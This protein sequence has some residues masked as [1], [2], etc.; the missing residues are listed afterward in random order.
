VNTSQD[1]RSGATAAAGGDTATSP[2]VSAYQDA[3][4]TSFC[5][6]DPELLAL[7]VADL[8]CP[9]HGLTATLAPALRAHLELDRG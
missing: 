9:T 1:R 8:R 4:R 3:P 6:C 2:S 5:I 7:E